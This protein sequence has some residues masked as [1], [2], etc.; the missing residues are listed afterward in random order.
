[1]S[2]L[3]VNGGFQDGMTGW[4]FHAPPGSTAVVENGVM[5]LTVAAASD[6]IQLYQAGLALEPN[7]RYRLTF[8][9]AASGPHSLGVYVHRNGPPYDSFG[10]AEQAV[11][12]DT[13]PRVIS[14]DF[15]TPAGSL[16]DGR[17][18]FWLA[19]Y[20]AAGSVYRISDVW[21]GVPLEPEPEPPPEPDKTRRVINVLCP[22]LEP[23]DMLEVRY[24]PPDKLVVTGGDID[25]DATPWKLVAL[26]AHTD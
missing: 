17:L 13:Q 3:I 6:N 1:M 26:Y 8:T 12:V 9:A 23:G 10:L 4:T 16:I 11:D 5:Q 15:T 18:R 2:N 20:A 21:L 24:A 25:W 14:V 19:P 22:T 7:T